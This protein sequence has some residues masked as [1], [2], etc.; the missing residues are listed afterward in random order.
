MY[1]QEKISDALGEKL[2]DILVTLVE[3]FA[4]ST[5][6]IH[7]GRLGKFVRNVAL[8]NND[9][10]SGAVEQLERLTR[11]EAG[12]VGAET[13]TEAKKSSRIITNVAATLTDMQETLQ[14]DRTHQQ[15]KYISEALKIS[16]FDQQSVY[17]KINKARLRGTGDWVRSEPI[18]NMWL[19]RDFPVIYLSGNPGAGK[20]YLSTNMISLLYEHYPQDVKSHISVVYFFFKDNNPDTRSA[21]QALRDM[22]YQ[23]SLNDPTYQKYLVSIENFGRIGTL[24][25][26][27]KLLYVDFFLK[28]P[29]QDSCVYILL[30]GVSE[31]FDDERMAFLERAKE[32]YENP[33]MKRIQIAL[34]GRPHLRDQLHQNLELDDVPTIYV[35]PEKNSADIDDYIKASVRKSMILRK[36]SNKLRQDII[37][38]LSA[39]AEG[40]FLWV[41]L[42][43]QELEK[44]RSEAS[45]RNSL[46][47]APKGLK[48]TMRHV[49]SSYSE[50]FPAEE[51]EFL[52]EI[53]IW[54]ACATE[55][56]QLCFI[57]HLLK[58]KSKERDGMINLEGALRNQFASFF[59]LDREDGLTTAELHSLSVNQKSLGDSDDELDEKPHQD[60]VI[61]MRKDLRIPSALRGLIAVISP[62]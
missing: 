57:E 17:E 30:D 51:L 45:M 5:K 18:F 13:L 33:G 1:T 26:A 44:L 6:A 43:I 21:H 31:A 2:S 59:N 34:V 8:G 46:K 29:H 55:P 23:I 3:V 32:L 40:M 35:G 62:M 12:L 25:S 54:T 60:E 28:K 38:T 39:R 37:Q 41:N 19:K 53:L 50:N 24:K 16:R 56:L 22:A 49:L 61:R 11:T 7:P 52:N 4:L 14:S 36:V 10:I 15:R 42:M 27:W 47:D 9:P 48:E 58:L 20:S